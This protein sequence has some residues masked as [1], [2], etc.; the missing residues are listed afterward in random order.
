MKKFLLP[1]KLICL[2]VVL[3]VSATANGSEFPKLILEI[4]EIT[5]NPNENY[6]LPTKAGYLENSESKQTEVSVKWKVEPGY[7]GK[8]DRYGVFTAMH[9]GEGFLVAKYKNAGY[10]IKIKIP[11][12]ADHEAE[13]DEY[14]KI[15]IAPANV[16]IESADSVEL[17]AF[18]INKSGEK[19]DSTNDEKLNVYP[20]PF[21]S[22]TKIRYNLSMETEINLAVFNMFGQPVKQLVKNIQF[23]GMHTVTWDGTNETGSKVPNGIYICRML[24]NGKLYQVSRVV[25][26]R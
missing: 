7:L 6:Q 12:A 8:F 24:K 13:D 9:P 10:K 4:D 3:T 5:V 22:T 16:R 2:C 20:N 15:K 26:N 14:P 25:L 19:V 21:Y 17:R 23:E 1:L 11:G 18:Y